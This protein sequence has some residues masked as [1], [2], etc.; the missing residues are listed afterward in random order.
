MTRTLRAGPGPFAAALAPMPF[1]LL[2]DNPYSGPFGM[3]LL[4]VW[5]GSV[6]AALRRTGSPGADEPQASATPRSRASRSS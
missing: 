3:A 6:G 2:D 5:L 4:A 1:F